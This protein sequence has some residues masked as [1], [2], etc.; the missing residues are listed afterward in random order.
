M[1]PYFNK[2][3]LEIYSS[4]IKRHP[5]SGSISLPR[6]RDIPA[7]CLARVAVIITRCR[8]ISPAYPLQRRRSKAPLAVARATGISTECLANWATAVWAS[9]GLEDGCGSQ[10]ELDVSLLI[11]RRKAIIDLQGHGAHRG[12]V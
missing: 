7:F 5:C 9:H 4:A 11:D 2:I 6:R 10:L 3:G 1:F 12:S 8:A